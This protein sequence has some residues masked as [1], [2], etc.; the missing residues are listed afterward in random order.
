MSLPDGAEYW[1]DIRGHS[2]EAR[3]PRCGPCKTDR[4]KRQKAHKAC[5]CVRCGHPF[6]RHGR[7]HLPGG[8]RRHGGQ[9]NHERVDD[10]LGCVCHQFVPSPEDIAGH[11]G[12]FTVFE[13]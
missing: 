5:E 13:A 8:K 7:V 10:E 12:F 2:Y 4:E 9:C 11:G 1:W 6:G 3:E